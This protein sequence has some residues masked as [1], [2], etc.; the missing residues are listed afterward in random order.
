[1]AAAEAASDQAG[2]VLEITKQDFFQEA[3]NLIAQHYEK[4]NDNKVQGSSIN[5]FR[6][7][8]QKPKSGKFLPLEIKKK[9]TLDVAQERQT[10]HRHTCFP[11]DVSKGDHSEAPPQPPSFKEPHIFNVK[12]KFMG[13]IDLIAKEQVKLCKIVTNIESVGKQMEKEKQ[14][15][16]GKSRMLDSYAVPITKFGL[17]AQYMTSPLMGLLKGHDKAFYDWRGIMSRKSFHSSRNSSLRSF[18]GPPFPEYSTKGFVKKEKLV[19]KPEPEPQQRVQPS[20]LKMDKLDSKVKRIGPHIEIFQ[21]FRKRNKLIFTKKVIRMITVMQAHI[22]GWLERKRLRRIVI[23][24]L[25][26]GRN[27]RAVINIYCRLIH[28]VK[29]RLGL[30]RTRQIINFAELEEWMD[31]K[32]FYETMFAK[33]EDWQGLQKSELLK[34]FNDC[35]HFPIQQQI[36]H[37]WNLVHREDHEKYSEIIKKPNA[38]EMLFTLYPPQGAHVQNNM[39]LR[40]TWL[41]PIVDGEEG[42]KYIVS[43][44]PVLKRANIRIVGRLVAT[45]MRERKMRQQQAF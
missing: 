28:R 42:Y 13:S 10:A 27:L 15:Y 29:Y 36:D 21:V 3:K 7:K 17:H 41:R 14:R 40:S 19:F 26:H 44:H 12:E 20:P 39:R 34:Y 4:I 5:V 1:M 6:N 11:R 33:R 38:I 30:W 24:A 25:Y 32:K 35:G 18:S 16:H 2:P 8:H 9:E 45:Y 37:V 43:G 22:R 31:R 23:K